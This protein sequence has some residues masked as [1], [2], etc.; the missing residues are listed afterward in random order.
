MDL[1][2]LITMGQMPFLLSACHWRLYR[3]EYAGFD[4]YCREKWGWKR[5]HAY[6]L[7]DAA[8]VVKVS[9]IGDKIKTESQARELGKAEPE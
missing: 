4:E 5:D 3:R 2:I 8:E 1:K 9:P 6:R 7:I